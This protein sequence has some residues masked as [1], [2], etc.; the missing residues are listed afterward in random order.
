VNLA[1]RIALDDVSYSN[2]LPDWY[3]PIRIDYS[4]RERLIAKRIE[5][6][7]SG[8]RQPRPGLRVPVPRRSGEIR[9]WVVPSV[10]DQ[11][12]LQTCVSSLADSLASRVDHRRVFSCMRNDDPSRVAL[13]RDNLS[14]WLAF[15]KE[16]QT[17]L[18]ARPEGWIL[19]LD[20]RRAFPSFDR[21]EVYRFVE[22]LAPNGIAT[23]LLRI[24]LDTLSAGASGLPMINNAVFYLG[25]AYLSRV[26]ALM[27]DCAVNFIRFMDD[28]RVFGETQNEL[29]EAF[30][31]IHRRLRQEGFDLNLDKLKL[32]R[33]NDYLEAVESVRVIQGSE[34][35]L[36]ILL[37]RLLDPDQTA[38]LTVRVLQ[39]PERYLHE[40][41]GRF[42]LGNLRRFRYEGALADWFG[43]EETSAEDALR[44]TL[45]GEG[46]LPLA[47][48]LLDRYESEPQEA[49]RVVWLIYLLE[50]MEKQEQAAGILRRVETNPEMPEFARLWAR[51]ARRGR[52]R[53]REILPE[54]LHD[55]SY[56]EAGLRCYGDQPCDDGTS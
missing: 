49:W 7:V 8:R 22:D 26:D 44:E 48:G 43:T 2:P 10:N 11:I 18:T 15:Q 5:D 33:A 1:I 6:Y 47:L 46:A 54:D 25:N 32:G 30:E 36:S 14:T 35:Y 3:T 51:R 21:E 28:Y 13:T 17:R 24:L 45:E 4:K 41:F 38:A 34:S 42:L 31:R 37:T 16:T 20:L 12:L 39:E 50:L 23:R 40:G 55:E 9:E 29:E 56:L 53:E 52:T 19:Q 27:D